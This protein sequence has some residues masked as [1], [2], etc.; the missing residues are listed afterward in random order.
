VAEP[1]PL[2]AARTHLSQAEAAYRTEDGLFHLEEGLALLEEVALDGAPEHQAIA[3]NLLSTYSTRICE[4]IKA[5]VEKDSGL[6]E[7]DLEHLFKVLLAFDAGELELPEYVR[8]LK[9]DVVR[10]L[11]DLYYEGYSAEEKQKMFQ[12]LAEIAGNG[13]DS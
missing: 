7:P 4:S 6:P 2:V 5:L 9:I 13:T 10:R 12:Q 11:I 8:S 3:A 1:L